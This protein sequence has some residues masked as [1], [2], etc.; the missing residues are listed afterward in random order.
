MTLRQYCPAEKL[1]AHQVLD[2]VAQNLPVSED[3]IK[4][5]QIVLGDVA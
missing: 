1:R 4:D 5:A 3:E 2:R